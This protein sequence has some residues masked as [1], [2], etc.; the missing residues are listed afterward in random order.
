MSDDTYGKGFLYCLYEVAKH[1][2][3]VFWNKEVFNNEKDYTRIYQDFFYGVRDHLFELE[4][5]RQFKDKEIGKIAA[6]LKKVSEGLNWSHKKTE[7]EFNKF[8]DKCKTIFI[9]VDKELGVKVKE[10]SVH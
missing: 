7:E 1:Y 9:L 3:R 4:I 5:P 8:Y 2:E 10:G 6:E